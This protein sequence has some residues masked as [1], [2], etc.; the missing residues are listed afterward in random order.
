MKKILVFIIS[1]VLISNSFTTTVLAAS[2]INKTQIHKI[3]KCEKFLESDFFNYI[4]C[5]NDE[6]FISKK[7]LNSSK[8]KK[9]DIQN[10]LAIANILSENLE[11]KFINNSRAVQIWGKILN[12]PYKGKANKKKLDK[13]L[14]DASCTN[15]KDF[16]EFINCFYDEFRD[17]DAYKKSDLQNKRRIETI[18]SNALYLTRYDSKV[19]AE[20]KSYSEKGQMYSSD[21]GFDYFISYMD[22]LGS[23]YFIKS[24]N[25]INWKKVITFI[26]IAILIAYMAKRLLKKG[27]SGSSQSSVSSGSTSTAGAT[28]P[29]NSA[30]GYYNQIPVKY[31]TSYKVTYYKPYIDLT[32]KSWFKY[33][34]KSRFGF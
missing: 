24:K 6:V 16:D 34:M 10:L 15:L 1:V 4:E 28:N 31:S 8:N 13:I 18:V 2:I 21:Q 25:D 5:L 19:Y 7:F 30:T 33:A 20:A 32:Q 14:D 11:D 9:I 12:S 29:V 26:I 22:K 27:S 23:D 17:F 3:T